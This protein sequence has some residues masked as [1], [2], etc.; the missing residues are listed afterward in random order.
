MDCP[1]DLRRA[2]VAGRLLA[3]SR[4]AS[5][6]EFMQGH[7]AAQRARFKAWLDLSWPGIATSLQ[8]EAILVQNFWRF[9]GQAPSV[10]VCAMPTPMQGPFHG[11]R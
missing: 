6:A 10:W 1:E 2:A 4:P 9:L 7:R 3:H 8:R 5:G 11:T